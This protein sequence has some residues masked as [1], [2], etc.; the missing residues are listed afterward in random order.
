M[1]HAVQITLQ[2]FTEFLRVENGWKPVDVGGY[3]R[4]IVFDWSPFD[5]RPEI[6]VR[7]YSSILKGFNVS[8]KVGGDAIRVCAVDVKSNRGLI[9]SLRV[10]RVEGWRDNLKARVIDI[11]DQLSERLRA[12]AAKEAAMPAPVAHASAAPLFELLKKAGAN[13]LKQPKL[14]FE[15]AEG[16]RLVVSVAGPK[17]KAPGT[18]NL[19]DGG[20]YGA[21]QWFGR[22]RLDGSI[23]QSSKWQPWVGE[24]LLAFAQ[25]PA[26]V[27]AA[28]GKKTGRCCFCGRHLETKESTAVGYGPICAEKFGLP[29]GTVPAEEVA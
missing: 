12:Q 8:R 11:R 29:W 3:C 19:T 9:S 27:G 15:P 20:P 1:S 4:E 10:Y 2:E 14:R 25:D 6:V 16:Q 13:G 21:N 18:L 22:V 17:S 7:V 23:F 28:Y 5:A 26:K 24:L